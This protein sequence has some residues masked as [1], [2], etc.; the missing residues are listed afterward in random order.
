MK[1][2]TDWKTIAQPW[3]LGCLFPLSW[4]S[5][6]KIIFKER[7]KSASFWKTPR[8]ALSITPKTPFKPPPGEGLR[9]L[10]AALPFSSSISPFLTWPCPALPPGSPR[11]GG[12]RSSWWICW[13]NALEEQGPRGREAKPRGSFFL[14]LLH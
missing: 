13:R 2:K 5:K 3:I 11:A 7:L 4:R 12:D 14:L 1:A 6:R 10:K 8:F 9:W